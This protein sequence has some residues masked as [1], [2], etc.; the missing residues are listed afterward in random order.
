[1]LEKW[2]EKTD[3]GFISASDYDEVWNDI[4]KVCQNIASKYSP[5]IK[6]CVKEIN[7]I[8]FLLKRINAKVIINLPN[9]VDKWISDRIVEYVSS[10]VFMN[11]DKETMLSKAQTSA[12]SAAN[13]LFRDLYEIWFFLGVCSLLIPISSEFSQIRVSRKGL[14][15]KKKIPPNCWF[16]IKNKYINLFLEAPRYISWDTVEEF[17]IA[18]EIKKSPRPDIMIYITHEPLSDIIDASRDPP[19]KSPNGIVEIKCFNNWWRKANVK[20]QIEK[21]KRL[22]KNLAIASRV[23]A[24]TEFQG[25]KVFPNISFDLEKVGIVLKYILK[26]AGFRVGE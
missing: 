10:I 9:D 1:M 4:E 15:L 7:Q 25:V 19:I 11:A 24:P 3:L 13:A 18:K 20:K 23:D 14:Q 2:R 22:C 21:Y 8:L 5:L 12:K 16:E 26:N 17:T 6:S